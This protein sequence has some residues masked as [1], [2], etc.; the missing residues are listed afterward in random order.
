MKIFF[1]NI[2]VCINC[3]I[4]SKSRYNKRIKNILKR[5]MYFSFSY[6]RLWIMQNFYSNLKS[7]KL[8]SVLILFLTLKCHSSEINLWFVLGSFSRGGGG[9]LRVFLV[10][11][12][13][14]RFIRINSVLVNCKF[15]FCFCFFFNLVLKLISHS[16]DTYRKY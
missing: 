14:M 9:L 15:R 3:I 12:F 2:F 10:G 11:F 16:H 8:K 7:C 1:R 5:T 4:N 6:I 13:L